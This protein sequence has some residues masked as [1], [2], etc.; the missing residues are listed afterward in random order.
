[1]GDVVFVPSSG[2]VAPGLRLVEPAFV[3]VGDHTLTVRD[4]IV[5]PSGTDV[6]L[7]L[8]RGRAGAELNSALT[9]ITLLNGT[10]SYPLRVTTFSASAESPGLLRWRIGSRSRV[11]LLAG[12]VDALIA[13]ANLGEA[14]MPLRLTPFGEEAEAFTCNEDAATDHDGITVVLRHIAV[15]AAETALDFELRPSAGI[16]KFM[17]IGGYHGLRLGATAL[18]MRDQTGREYRELFGTERPRTGI[19]DRDYAVFESLSADAR[20]LELEIPYVF[21][22]ESDGTVA[23]ELPLEGPFSA[24]FGS[25]LIGVVSARSISARPEA[26]SP[27]YRGGAVGLQLEYGGWQGSR[28]V[29]LPGRVLVDRVPTGVRL[30]TG[31]DCTAPEPVNYFEVPHMET[32]FPRNVELLGPIVQVRGPWLLRFAR[33]SGLP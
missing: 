25:C 22:E 2:F 8:T 19:F 11:P 32:V 21:A 23:V 10:G 6:V 24:R 30:T 4:L 18:K 7:D 31:M 26:E 13:L 12:P 29:L 16:A 20:R 15:T 33:P 27:M 9:S 17:G 5:T 28:R 3:S 1:M 14:R